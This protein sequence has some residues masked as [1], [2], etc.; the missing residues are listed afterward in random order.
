MPIHKDFELIQE[1]DIPEINTKGKLY[2]HIPTGA[3]LLSMENDDENKCFCIT[4]R[5][6]L[7]DST[8]VAHIMEHA[9]LLGSEKYPVKEPFIELVKGSLQTFVN[10]FTFPDKTIYPLASQNLQDFYNLI[11]VYME[12]VLR[13]L[14]T[15][16]GF[17]QEGWHFELEDMDSPLT[18]KGV[19]F[20]EMKGA[21]SDPQDLL[22]EY[23]QQ[24]LF[25]DTT[26]Y[27]VDSGGHPENIPDLTYEQ[28]KAFHE[29]FYHPSNARIYWY[30]DDPPEER[31]K[32]TA[33]YLKGYEKITVES[34]VPL[35]KKF[36]KPRSITKPYAVAE[37]EQ[38]AKS[39]LCVNWLL[40]DQ[41]HPKTTLSLAIL[42]HILV[43]TQAS[44]LR[45][46]LID[47]GLGEDLVG[48]GL[49]PYL[50]QLTFS[51]GLKGIESKDASKVERLIQETL[52]SLAE[53]GIDPN[54][55]A[56]SM[57]T[58][59]FQLRENNSGIYPRGLV[60]LL[61]A[62][63]TWLYDGDPLSPIAYA[64]PLQAIKEQIERGNG[65]FEGLIKEHFI[66]NPH[67]VTV[68]LEPDPGLDQRQSKEEAARLA[69]ARESMS[70]SELQAI[71]D[72]T[73]KLIEIQNTPDTPEALA[74]LPALILEDL[75][76]E[77]KV[78]PQEEYEEQGVSVLYHDIFTNGIVYLDLGFDLH[79]VPQEYLPY[80][81][82]FA[83]GLIKMG[84]KTEDFV[85]LSQRIGRE[86]GGITPSIFSQQVR[87]ST[88]S[89]SWLILRGKS[90]IDK[91]SELFTI[92]KDIL[93]T[94][95]F[96]NQERFRQILLERKAQM[97]A[98]L[99]PSGHSFVNRRLRGKQHEAGW[100][101]EQVSGFD[102]L[103]FTR[104]LIEQ[105]EKDW[106]GVLA[107]FKDIQAALIDRS[108]MVAN[109]TVDKDNWKEVKPQISGFLA[110]IP[111]KEGKRHKWN[112][113]YPKGNEGLTIP[114]QV[115]YVGK[116]TNLYDLGYELDGSVSVVRKYLGTTYLW[117]KIRIQG[118]AYGVF[119]VFDSN[120]G[121]LNYI[122]Y[123]DPN[124]IETLDNYDGTPTFLDKLQISDSELT[125][126]IIGA[127]G[128]MDT[129]QL[130][131]AKG[132]S[133][134]VRYLTGY[135][136]KE[137]QEIRDEV[138]ST[139]VDDFK[140][141]GKALEKV[142]DNG[143][144]VVLGSAESIG[145]ANQERKAFLKVKKVM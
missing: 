38:D 122:S 17:E 51:T 69:K 81:E 135:T 64:A 84:T 96:D 124:L 24:N 4:F 22:G 56:A 61:N 10:A 60:F 95:K 57:N 13:P 79:T 15:R 130:P 131:D 112:P 106:S 34:S 5:T 100:V 107:K 3:E 29:T 87:H 54:M 8:G 126:A 113:D 2:R 145:A 101:T 70:E 36:D 33:E 44:P 91:I 114:A 85:K 93:L 31:L 9:A 90:T 73:K 16:H 19:V 119:I 42:N 117:E 105:V 71:I 111:S 23:N 98:A 137:R 82:L 39:Y 97:E 140:T 21:Y 63:G 53:T 138:L 28:F 78:I 80:L 142:I 116:G 18:Y 7:E 46:A 83:S 25:P 12:S 55:V 121:T 89:A 27:N 41:T 143:Q 14:L 45:K 88:D 11:D 74:T 133:T 59:E 128:E 52:A 144:V 49:S 67:R 104:N 139:T 35:Q 102:N 68:L 1:R 99:L 125:K 92:L 50:R 109:F 58:V 127:I 40:P 141:F 47:S 20:N 65:Y 72:N 66:D 75:D 62:M 86:T 77:N 103:D 30:G 136:D 129:H 94:T 32:R 110:D 120:A 108:M 132:Y 123:R 115:N 76:K 48:G 134:L 37:D 43:G 118:G 26:T 6:P